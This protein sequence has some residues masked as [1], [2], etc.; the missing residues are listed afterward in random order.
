VFVTNHVLAGAAIGSRVDRP[1]AAFVTGVASHFVLDAIPHWGDPR[2]EVFIR[3]AV[4]DGL[5]GLAALVLTVGAARG[6]RRAAV[7]AGALG[8][9]FPDLDK[10]WREVFGRSPFPAAV[11][12]FHNGIQ[13]EAPHRARYEIAAAVVGALAVSWLLSRPQ[14]PR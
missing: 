1:A 10:P 11:D 7:L 12:S 5:T 14:Q 4:A 3:A 2:R 8:A 13:D 6:D 9:A